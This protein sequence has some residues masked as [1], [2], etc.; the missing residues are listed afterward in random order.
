[1]TARHGADAGQFVTGWQILAQNAQQNLAHQ[2]FAN[3]QF[4]ILRDPE[5]HS[6]PESK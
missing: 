4:A 5:S 2:L 1:M 3:R 6:L